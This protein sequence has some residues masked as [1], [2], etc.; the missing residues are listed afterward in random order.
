[1]EVIYSLAKVSEIEFE[2]ETLTIPHKAVSCV[3]KGAEIFIP[4]EG[5]VDMGTEIA[6]LERKEESRERN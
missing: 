2:T 3:I 5:L 4:M 6:R 1:M